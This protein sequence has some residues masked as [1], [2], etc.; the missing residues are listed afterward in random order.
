M[1]VWEEINSDVNGAWYE[2]EPGRILYADSEQNANEIY[3]NG[4]YP[5]SIAYVTKRYGPLS[6]KH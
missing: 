5:V 2:V 1:R 6:E 4:A 3:A